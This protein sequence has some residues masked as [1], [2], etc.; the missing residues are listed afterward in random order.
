MAPGPR[1]ERTDAQ[2]G[3]WEAEIVSYPSQALAE[4]PLAIRVA[5]EEADA[6]YEWSFSDG[7]SASGARVTKVFADSGVA[8]ARVRIRDG[9][10]HVRNVERVMRVGPSISA[11]ATVL[12]GINPGGLHNCAIDAIQS[13]YCWGYNGHGTVGDGTTTERHTPVLVGGSFSQIATGHAHSCALTTAGAAYCWGRNLNGALGDGTLT[14]RVTPTAV[15]GG[16]VF[17]SIDVGYDH[18]C[19]I[20]E[21]GAAY[22]WGGNGVGQL[23]EGQLVQSSN[24]PVAV[25]GGLAFTMIRAGY[26]HSCAIQSVTG[27]AY[28]WGSNWM[29][30]LGAGLTA[31]F[32]N[33]PTAVAGGYVYTQLDV[34]GY[35]SCGTTSTWTYCW[36][37]NG[38]GQIGATT[39]T[40]CGVSQPC[41]RAPV[42]LNS[43]L[44]FVGVS[45]GIAHSCAIESTGDIHCWG[46]NSHGQ[47]GD[48]TTVDQPSAKKLVTSGFKTILT[49]GSFS[50]GVA[51]DNKAWCWGRN[52][53][54]NLGLGDTVDR[55]TPTMLPDLNF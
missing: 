55:L 13:L 47:I 23:G 51:L 22:C 39:S 6:T 8:V 21:S 42:R 2:N 31:D 30:Q 44:R 24:V 1:T 48:G 52:L 19:G 25:G 7:T 11:L 35:H 32:L 40:T 50:C 46:S 17:T 12:T 36:G 45:A 27:F 14:D 15:Q 43:S 38:R 16:L 54:G 41:V 37:W 49:G 10:G 20:V 28:C 53:H 18:S 9:S 33:V 29:G 5:R 26:F 3:A 4:Y 34:G